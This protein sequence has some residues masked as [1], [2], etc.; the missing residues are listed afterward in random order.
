MNSSKQWVYTLVGSCAPLQPETKSGATAQLASESTGRS[1]P[2]TQSKKIN[3]PQ[4]CWRMDATNHLI[5]VHDKN[6]PN[7][8]VFRC[9]F[10]CQQKLTSLQKS[11]IP[12]P[13]SKTPTNAFCRG[14][15]GRLEKSWT[16][17]SVETSHG[18]FPG[19]HHFVAAMWINQ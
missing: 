17:T 6:S 18:N 11:T 9:R 4:N 7:S 8:Q 15:S 19:T 3:R 10:K 12:N 5:I 14:V 13:N 2:E 1:Y 16:K